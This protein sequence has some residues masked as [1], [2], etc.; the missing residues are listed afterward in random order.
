MS[1][2]LDVGTILRASSHNFSEEKILIIS[3]E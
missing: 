3:E 2:F 1:P